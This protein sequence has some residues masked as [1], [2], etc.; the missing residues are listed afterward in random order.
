MS[1]SKQFQRMHACT[2]THMHG[3]MHAHTHINTIRRRLVIPAD[4]ETHGM[5]AVVNGSVLHA[6]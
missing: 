6:L 4:H 1:L 5:P 2:H 3:R